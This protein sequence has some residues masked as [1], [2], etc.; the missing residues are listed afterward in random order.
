MTISSYL[1]GRTFEASFQAA[2][3]SRSGIRASVAQGGLSPLLLLS[4]YVNYTPT[5]FHHVELAVY[6]DD[7]AI[8]VTSRK[9]TL[10]VSYL[11]LPQRLRA[12]AKRME[13]LEHKH[14]PCY[15]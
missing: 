6:A 5:P 8:L 4:L 9:P 14:N 13:T 3:S 12:L 7:T 11:K 10:L 2:T 15:S 1:R